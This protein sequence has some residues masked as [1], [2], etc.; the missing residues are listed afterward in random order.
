[1]RNLIVSVDSIAAI[2]EDRKE[3]EPD[4]VT[5]AAAAELAGADGIA[6]HVRLDRKH[7]RDRD[8][9]I[10]R[11]TVKTKLVLYIAPETEMIE[12]ALEVKPA[13]VTLV[14]ERRE[15]LTTESGLSFH[16]QADQIR[17]A[18]DQLKAAGCKVSGVVEPESDA[19]KNA[20]R[21]GLDGVELFCHHYRETRSNAESSDELQRLAKTA[22]AAKKHELSVRA[23]GG[24]D[25]RNIVPL[26]SAT[27]IGEF[28]VGHCIVSR[29]VLV[30]IE[31]AVKEMV[32]IV[33][34]F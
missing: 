33:K 2:R 12:R 5:A 4:P 30:G 8:L 14:P 9:Y 22:E 29:A 17:E 24:L 16:D 28:T 18:C 26:L 34:Y 3:K 32:D 6:V 23:A 7:S 25:Y 27:E 15:E 21:M 19:L 10:L 1:M 13:E 31:R 20:L 11:E